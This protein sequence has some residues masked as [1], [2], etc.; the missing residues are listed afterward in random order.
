VSFDLPIEISPLM[1]TTP[2]KQSDRWIVAVVAA[3]A[4]AAGWVCWKGNGEMRSGSGRVEALDRLFGK[5]P[6]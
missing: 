6:Q 4:L 5:I 2:P 3:V 1:A